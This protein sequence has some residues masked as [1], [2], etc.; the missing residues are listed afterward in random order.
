MVTGTALQ[1]IGH[2][3]GQDRN[4]WVVFFSLVGVDTE[5]NLR[6]YI[7]FFYSNIQCN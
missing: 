2:L 6:A 3:L 7:S 4:A 1:Y 5:L